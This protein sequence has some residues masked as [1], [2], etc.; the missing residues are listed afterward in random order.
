MATRTRIVTI[1]LALLL[2]GTGSGFLLAYQPAF[3][4][5]PPPE[6][7]T[8]VN[9]ASSA[10]SAD[11]QGLAV[12]LGTWPTL[13]HDN[14]H[15]GYNP[16]VGSFRPPLT[17]LDTVE[18]AEVENSLGQILNLVTGPQRIFAM[19]LYEIWGV[20]KENPSE[21]WVN[22]DCTVDQSG[23][24]C[25]YRY[26][27][28]SS[29]RLVV[30]RQNFFFSPTLDLGFELA[31]L[32]APTGQEIWSR[33]L[34]EAPP[35]VALDGSYIL[36]L[37]EASSGGGRLMKL[38]LSGRQEYLKTA[39]Y[40]VSADNRAVVAGGRFIYAD[41]DRI[42][43]YN[44]GDGT[45][46]WVYTPTVPANTYGYDLAATAG[47]I[48]VS[49]D[50]RV[51]KLN[52]ADGGFQWET[53]LTPP[54]CSSE[55]GPNGAA[56][57]GTIIAITAVCDEEIVALNYASGAEEWRESLG[58]VSSASAVAIGGDVL[59]AAAVVTSTTYLT[60][61]VYAFDPGTGAELGRIA[62]GP[63]DNTDV[64]A[65]SDGLLLTASNFGTRL[66]QRFE[67][68]PADLAA[69]LSTGGLP[70]CGVAV[71]M[72]VTFNFTVTNNG[73]GGTDNT[74]ADLTLPD[75]AA[76]LQASPGS[77]TGG[78]APFCE[79][80]ALANG[81]SAHIT[82]TVELDTAGS[83]L[84]GITLSGDV[85]DPDP[86]NDTISTT[87]DVDVAPP[88][89]LDLT[90]ADI[91]ITQ[92]VQDLFN[93][94]FMVQG[95]TTFV[96]L[97]G[98]TNG[99]TVKNVSAVLHGTR[100]HTSQELGTLDPIDRTACLTLDDTPDRDRLRDSF[101]F[102]LPPEWVEGG[103]EFTAEI[104]P[105]GIISETNMSNNT[106]ERNRPFISYPRICL[107]TYPVRTSGNGSDNLQPHF[108]SIFRDDGNIL[109]RALTMLPV[110]EIEVFP[111][112]HLI[113]EWEP[114]AFG[115]WGP[116]EM[117]KEEDNRG[118]VLDTLW[119]INLFTDDPDECDADDSR[120]HYVGMV[121]QDTDNS[122]GSAGM[123][124]RDG[125]ELML[126]LNTGPNG[127]QRFDDPHGGLTLAH[128]IGHNYDRGH[129]DCD[130]PEDPDPN[131]PYDP[132]QFAPGSTKLGI[133][134]LEF[135]DPTAPVVITPTMAGDLMS[136]ADDVW[137]SDYTWEA[138]QDKLCEASNCL[139]S[140]LAV[141]LTNTLADP[142]TITG[143]V[144]VIRGWTSPTLMVQD[145]IRLPVS[146]VPEANAMWAKQVASRPLTPTY[147]LNLISGTAVLHS[148]PFTPTEAADQATSRPSFGLIVPWI[149]GTTRV[150]L[151]I[152]GAVAISLTA[153]P[154]PPT[155]TAVSPDGGESFTDT[156]PVTWTAVDPDGDDLRYTV[157]YSGD[158]GGSW[159]ALATGVE[160]TTITVDATLLPGSAGQS[161]V[162]VIASDGLNAASRQSAAGFTL[163]DR[164]PLAAIIFPD[165]GGVYSSTSI[166]TLQGVVYDPEEGT[167]PAGVMS[168]T[169]SGTGPVGL[170]D[171]IT[172]SG[173]ASGTYTLTLTAVDSNDQ[174][175]SASV[176]FT[177]VEPPIGPPI[178][179][180]EPEGPPMLYLP[181]ITKD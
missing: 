166:L 39:E 123:G 47:A 92:G 46:S 130:D 28:Y 132:C 112:S 99:G 152:S 68:E 179:P 27:A 50:E 116:Y 107:M 26:L 59:Y 114:F 170:G 162:K 176:V 21:Q 24:F 38:T 9:G 33:D 129:V 80:G 62:L 55:L 178:Q 121:H 169:L 150:E 97:Y 110:R 102:Q 175:G 151:T 4:I 160:T 69:G 71:G 31:V 127:P 96:R 6:N 3:S 8:G 103:I 122:V 126:F 86:A 32:N 108:Q 11:T 82:A 70:A 168:W 147:A 56:T 1:L 100:L 77:C 158:G 60:P 89:D 137:P 149:T 76:T 44:T 128:E 111:N 64:L 75:G 172:L 174:A 135:R 117:E 153:S 106:L 84:P 139:G 90:L 61:T 143:D 167:L 18:L 159:K 29:D 13:R 2:V 17:R 73:P 14:G 67:R 94:V 177:I 141:D 148:E 164:S 95:K 115:G 58:Q 98:Q 131:Y 138:I 48:I 85:R 10:I 87:L 157:L 20:D 133:Y 180:P 163:P 154:S 79:L 125:D 78:A 54:P 83:Y 37:V 88:A 43:A 63:F 105:G 49:Y 12:A 23:N 124:I 52:A 16:D 142:P 15:S 173:L 140:P 101:V 65:I 74:R 146:E 81:Q 57:D 34:G 41:D 51:I 113:E 36:A 30:V 91:E 93:S 119:W 165:D 136:Y 5:E 161:L 171:K 25:Q 19:G 155:V 109:S 145:Q 156:F 72:A 134:G 35:E 66:L 7:F 22:D 104:N 42:L 144:L 120:T 45:Q 53:D 181:M 40:T 118:D